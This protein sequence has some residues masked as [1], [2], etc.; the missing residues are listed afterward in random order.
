MTRDDRRAWWIFGLSAVFFVV[1]MIV[2][3]SGGVRGSDQYWYLADTE[4]LLRGEPPR[5]NNLY[6]RQ[7]LDLGLARSPMIHDILP[8]RGV[9][10]LARLIGAYPAWMA[11]NTVAM[12]AG[13]LLLMISSRRLAGP[14]VAA[15]LAG[16]LLLL[17]LSMASATQMLAEA[18]LV[19]F[20]AAVPLLLSR[21]PGALK[22]AG[23]AVVLTLALMTRITMIPLMAL[24]P[25]A[26][27][28][29]PLR[30]PRRALLVIWAAALAA[31]G[32][33]LDRHFFDG[34]PLPGNTLALAIG[35][36]GMELWFT[37]EPVAL[38]LSTVAAK[39]AS[40]VRSIPDGPMVN[41]LF[42]ASNWLLLMLGA[43]GVVVL[44]KR[45]S[46]ERD[47]GS[48]RARGGSASPQEV[49]DGGVDARRVDRMIA[50]FVAAMIAITL[51]TLALY[52]NQVRY[53]LP[54]YPALLLALAP[55]VDRLGAHRPWLSRMALPA[56]L[57]LL[58]P[59]ALSIA[60]KSR[61]DGL[62]DAAERARFKQVE[63]AMG[64]SGDVIYVGG[65]DQMFAYML[66][67]RTVLF[68]RAD[69]PAAH[70]ER[71]LSMPRWQWIACEPQ[72]ME[73][74]RSLGA[75]GELAMRFDYRGRPMVLIELEG[76]RRGHAEPAATLFAPIE[77]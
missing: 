4:T 71:I 41:R 42:A 32:V 33:A 24:L 58:A 20:I 6:P 23:L 36:T 2:G 29:E 77:P 12:L 7:L 5:S 62:R 40:F 34:V 13:A 55:I 56:G 11:L 8:Q 57:A 63:R 47:D 14:V 53:V 65:F 64:G 67:P 26:A 18:A 1:C 3:T 21:P 45:C 43:W 19:P 35:G 72:H 15:V 50:L 31:A 59:V 75:V 27:L 60:W 68:T 61:S 10:P 51:A 44:W 48:A 46:H 28:A 70:W 73:R 30:F 38:S 22:Y 69:Q 16:A 25:L 74:L 9:L 54:A 66:R 17:P 39:L 49:H 76:G 37:T 52:Q